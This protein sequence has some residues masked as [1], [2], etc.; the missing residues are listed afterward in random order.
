MQGLSLRVQWEWLKQID[1]SKPWQGL[2]MIKDS[3]AHGVFNTLVHITVG[4]GGRVL[5][6]QDRW[7]EGQTV[8]KIAP[9]VANKIKTQTRNM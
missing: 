9:G 1:P 5:F 6:W 7:I 8:A 3:K 2:P 4:G